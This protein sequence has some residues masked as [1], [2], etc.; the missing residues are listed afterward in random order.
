MILAVSSN[1]ICSSVSFEETE[2]QVVR[3]VSSATFWHRT[4]NLLQKQAHE[5][6]SVKTEIHS[7]YVGCE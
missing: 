2:K 7:F 4:V 6:I 3:N 5:R 1:L